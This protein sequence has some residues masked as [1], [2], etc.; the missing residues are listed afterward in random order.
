L[1]N[2]NLVCQEITQACEEVGRSVDE[3]KIM[4]VS[5]TYPLSDILILKD[6]GSNCFGENRAQEAESKI[7]PNLKN[8]VEMHFIGHLQR[9]K[10]KKVLPL[11][12]WIDSVDSVRLINE[13]VK[14]AEDNQ[15]TEPVNILFE[16]NTSGEEQK[17]G[18]RTANQ[19]YELLTVF[20]ER[21]EILQVLK[22]R[23]LMTIGPLN[24]DRM[25]IG[26]AFEKLRKLFEEVNSEGL[27]SNFDTLSM[28][29]SGDFPIAIAEG[30]TL[31]RI[32]TRIFGDRAYA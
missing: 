1:K 5:K 14:Q 23:G 8:Q 3:V 2:Y 10:V 22:P 18:L 16:M 26:K 4:C 12:N 9:N 25:Q 30:S 32:G 19:L 17:F 24:N 20:D 11:F 6:Q 27:F 7:L 28:G 31:V 13:L 15:R 21:P 29:M